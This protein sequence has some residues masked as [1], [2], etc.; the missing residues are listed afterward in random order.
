MAA[1]SQTTVVAGADVSAAHLS[2]PES[3][4]SAMTT[5]LS[6]PESHRLGSPMVGPPPRTC[7]RSPVT[8]TVAAGPTCGSL[9]SPAASVGEVPL[10]VMYGG[11]A[12]QEWQHA[13]D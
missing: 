3:C 6:V 8:P 2:P 1:S 11:K 13:E 10:A 12:P 9:I 7:D 5:G 4:S